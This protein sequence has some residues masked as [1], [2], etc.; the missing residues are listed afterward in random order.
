MKVASGKFLLRLPSELHERVRDAASA[1][2][3]SLN[4]YCL[5][6]LEAAVSRAPEST[7]EWL[8]SLR[9]ELG[10]DLVG[11]VLFGSTARGTQRAGSDVDLLIV[12]EPGVPITRE[13]Y[14]R[15]D[16]AIGPSSGAETPHF[17]SLPATVDQA[18]GLWYEVAMDGIV[19]HDSRQRIA[20]FFSEVRKAAA[21][22]IIRRETAHGHPYWVHA[23][24][25]EPRA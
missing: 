2:G 15:W 14:R 18:G 25:V 10:R 11:V 16:G 5:A 20:R 6:V 7:P 3:R 23:S 24:E 12:L 9:G 22:G 19:L 1:R 17:V 13:L 8:E 4:E 21:A